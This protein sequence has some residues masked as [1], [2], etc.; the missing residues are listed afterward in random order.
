VRLA[1]ADAGQL[2][3]ALAEGLA[4]L[5]GLFLGDESIEALLDL[6]VSV[7]RATLAIEGASV[8]LL[9]P[10]RGWFETL[11]A[12]SPEIDHIDS[13]QYKTGH[14]PC[15]EASTTGSVVHA[16]FAD[17][18]IRWPEF[19]A[20][21]VEHGMASVLST[22]LAVRGKTIGALNLYDT[23]ADAFGPEAV[24]TA[25]RFAAQASVV[26]ANAVAFMSSELANQSLQRA[27]ATRD[28]IGQAKGVLMARSNI[29]AEE[30]FDVLRRASQ[31]TNRK[32][33]DIA[34]DVVTHAGAPPEPGVDWK[35]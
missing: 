11:N 29:T 25:G 5:S 23:H 20:V 2:D 14:G 1:V 12:T 28:L 31:R 13:L 8:T 6:C 22:P 3:A 21:A 32:L 30:A 15:L 9:R 34:A 10:E 4:R 27:L 24:A 17:E 18:P 35:P 26:L 16:V 7:A 19:T 33:H